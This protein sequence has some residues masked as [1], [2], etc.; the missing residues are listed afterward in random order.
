[1][2]MKKLGSL[3]M[4]GVLVGTMLVGCGKGSSSE[5]K[6]AKKE[7]SSDA[8]KVSLLCVG[9]LGDKGFNDSLMCLNRDMILLFQELGQQKR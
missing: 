6:D 2:K 1:M 3:M 4:V 9:N 8:M 7:G 5:T